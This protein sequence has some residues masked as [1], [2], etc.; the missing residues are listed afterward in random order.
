MVVNFGKHFTKKINERKVTWRFDD[1]MP[2]LRKV[3]CEKINKEMG[4]QT[5]P[6]GSLY[7][8]KIRN[9]RMWFA[10]TS[11]F[12]REIDHELQS[13]FTSKKI[14]DDLRDIE[15]KPPIVNQQ[16]VVYEYK[17]DLTM[18]DTNYIGYTCRHLHQRV[19]ELKHSVI[20]KH[21]KDKHTHN[22]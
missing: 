7:L 14:V 6:L 22:A 1:L 10:T 21:L 17:C 5:A 9:L 16:S 20:R 18:C 15:F 12:G 11:Q 3:K 4:Y 2:S 8:I 19:K 13:I